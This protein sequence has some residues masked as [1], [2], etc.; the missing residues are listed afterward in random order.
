MAVLV[1]MYH[2]TP[3]SA[4]SKYEV[5]MKTFCEQIDR[6]I[7]TGV[8]FIP[9]A[10][11]NMDRVLD[12]CLHVALTFDDGHMSN[13]G[14]FE[15]LARRCIRPT[16]FVV[17]SLAENHSEFMPP[18]LLRRFAVLCDFGAHGSTHTDLTAL[19]VTDL[20][21]ELESS[22]MFL[23]D[24]LQRPIASMALPGGRG[25]RRVL[26]SACECGFNLVGNSIRDIHRRRGVSINR[27]CVTC[28]DG[29][30]YPLD[31]A[32]ATPAYWLRNR[33][34]RA[35]VRSAEAVLGRNAY[36]KF[37]SLAKRLSGC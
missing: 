5:P 11:V 28:S 26:R 10:D 31:L 23:E 18:D 33:A 9:F 19:S 22:R 32:L 12:D 30:S 37:S 15:F 3:V 6:M 4:T 8:S 29:S 35:V 1:L 16:A 27:V 21:R 20:H 25:N 17:R 7:D 24:T 36:S 13:V 34:R 2:Q 14:A